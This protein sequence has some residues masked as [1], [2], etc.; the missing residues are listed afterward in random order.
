MKSLMER[1]YVECGR[2]R[3][4]DIRVEWVKEGIWFKIRNGF[5]GN[6]G[7]DS[8]M[9]DFKVSDKGVIKGGGNFMYDGIYDFDMFKGGVYD[10]VEVIVNR[11][12]RYFD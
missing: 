2:L 10:K 11:L 8:V 7:Y 12:F 4:W 5:N 6:K 9:F 3:G 1:L